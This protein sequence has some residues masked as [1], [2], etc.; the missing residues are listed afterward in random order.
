MTNWREIS[1]ACA[2]QTASE[3]ERTMLESWLAERPEN[4]DE[5]VLWFELHDELRAHY[6][7]HDL[8]GR[9][10]ISALVPA[11]G[12]AATLATRPVATL[13]TWSTAVAAVLLAA[14]W[15][16]GLVRPPFR[17][18]SDKATEAA[19]VALV[20]DTGA[21][22]SSRSQSRPVA[23]TITGAVDCQWQPGV[24]Q[25]GYGEHLAAGT[26]LR[27]AEGL[28]QVTYESGAKVVIR[29][30]SEF[31]IDG[32]AEGALPVGQ[33]TAVVPRRAVG[34]LVTTPCAEVIDLG[35][36]FAVDVDSSGTSEVHVFK[37]EVV[38]R[39]LASADLRQSND[40][41]NLHLVTNEAVEYRPGRLEAREF[42]ADAS[43]FIR[44]ITPRLTAS[45]LPSAPQ[46]RGL[47]MWLAADLLVKTDE[48]QR[49]VAWQ[50]VL[51]G[52]NQ[53]PDDALQANSWAR[54]SLDPEALNGG[55]GVRFDGHT[56]HLVTTPMETAGSQ[57]VLIAAQYSETANHHPG[58]LL[59]YNGPPHRDLDHPAMRSE[60]GVL[61]IGLGRAGAGRLGLQAFVYIGGSVRSGAV[62]SRP[63]DA[64]KP[65]IL[66]YV[67]SANQNLARLLINGEVQAEASAPALAS[68]T[69][70]RVIGRHGHLPRFFHGEIGEVLIYN[71]TLR[72]AE[73]NNLQSYL[74]R[75]YAIS[76]AG[77]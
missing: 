6:R 26:V 7:E 36:E 2:D 30:P 67:Y 55:G 60:Q 73:L 12:F 63:V 65:F 48:Q 75:K 18:A 61:Q 56:T 25:Y 13:I 76:L 19:T 54:P 62:T 58:S 22:D 41:D 47:A 16:G 49:V 46:R 31:R 29:G 24:T 17:G 53:I 32:P 21:A 27:L 77:R 20:T 45:D 11:K 9:A 34:F 44:E 51:C 39:A 69:S 59:N 68:A 70:R 28:V 5:A 23:A 74:S 64:E 40:Q 10:G 38:S 72:K 3:A 33:I 42:P 52:S 37:G 1:I 50:D 66:A 71:R 8:Q 35:T 57:T 14:L 4:A 15:S 43:K